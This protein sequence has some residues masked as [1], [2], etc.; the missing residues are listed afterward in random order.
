MLDRSVIPATAVAVLALSSSA[1]AAGAGPSAT[2]IILE[3]AL[4]AA[5]VAGLALRG[6]AARLAAA[7]RGRLQPA[8]RRRAASARAR[9]V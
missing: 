9:G 6:P 1:S 4:A 3:L 2:P 8:A 5:A 7:V